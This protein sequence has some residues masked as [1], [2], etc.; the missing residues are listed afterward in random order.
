MPRQVTPYS[1]KRTK[2]SASKSDP[3]ALVFA[4]FATDEMTHT[5]PDKSTRIAVAAN[6]HDVIGLQVF[7]TPQTG[8]DLEVDDALFLACV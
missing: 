3:L 6:L 7:Q 5:T 1:A 4:P 2:G 8:A